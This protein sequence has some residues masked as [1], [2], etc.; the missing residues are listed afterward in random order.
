MNNLDTITIQR[1]H[2]ALRDEAIILHAGATDV[3][4]IS[5]RDRACL[6]E[7][8]A[9]MLQQ[10]KENAQRDAT[11]PTQDSGVFVCPKCGC[12]N[13]QSGPEASGARNVRCENGHCW[14]LT[15]TWEPSFATQDI[16]TNTDGITGCTCRESGRGGS[17]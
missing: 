12:D 6:R 13:F 10:H 9:A 2:A 5:A 11:T 17:R 4:V 16:G 3:L 8:L 15:C 14:N 7:E 1:A